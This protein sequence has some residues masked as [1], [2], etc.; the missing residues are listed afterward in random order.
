[1]VSAKKQA[2]IDI[3]TEIENKKKN[4]ILIM[5]NELPINE[6]RKKA[7]KHLLFNTHEQRVLSINDKL[8]N[9]ITDLINNCPPTEHNLFLIGLH[10]L[11]IE[12][13]LMSIDTESEKGKQTLRKWNQFIN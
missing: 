13:N 5:Q 4:A 10:T 2:E 3:K 12:T 11:K 1:M 6:K 9:G 8:E 7:D